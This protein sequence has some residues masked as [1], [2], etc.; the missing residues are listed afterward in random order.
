LRSIPF[1]VLTRIFW[2]L[3]EPDEMKVFERSCRIFRDVNLLHFKDVVL[4]S[5]HLLPELG[6]L[7]YSYLNSLSLLDDEAIVRIQLLAGGEP[8]P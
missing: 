5:K 1:A 4:Y 2:G 8:M 6:L 7:E 3:T